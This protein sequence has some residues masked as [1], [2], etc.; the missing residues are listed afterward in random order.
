[1][2]VDDEAALKW[3]RDDYV[4][5]EMEHQRD[6]MEEIAARHRGHV[7]KEGGVVILD[8]SDEEAPTPVCLGDPWHGN[9]KDDAPAGGND[10]DYTAF[11][12]LPGI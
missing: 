10:D 9:N 7:R 1:M 2:A 4:R 11:Y 12:K 3:A 5:E 6:V 8:K